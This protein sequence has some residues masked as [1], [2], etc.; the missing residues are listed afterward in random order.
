MKTMKTIADLAEDLNM[1]EKT[2]RGLVNGDIDGEP[3]YSMYEDREILGVFSTVY[4]DGDGGLMLFG[5][6]SETFSLYGVSVR[7]IDCTYCDITFDTMQ[8]IMK[9]LK[10]ANL[11]LD[12]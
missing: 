2:L 3:F 1:E 6:Y 8:E 7:F 4:T 5:G 11:R 9:E 10:D 12:S